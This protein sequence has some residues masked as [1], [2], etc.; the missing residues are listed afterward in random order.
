MIFH[1]ILQETIQPY[2][3]L[4]SVYDLPTIG[5]RRSFIIMKRI[6]MKK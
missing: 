1:I 6:L 4:L 2:M 3:V 5:V